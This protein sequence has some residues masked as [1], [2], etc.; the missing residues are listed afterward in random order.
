MNCTFISTQ[1]PCL[2]FDFGLSVQ[3]EVYFHLQSKCILID[4]CML[5]KCEGMLARSEWESL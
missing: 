1:P 4:F 5:L 2:L 3:F